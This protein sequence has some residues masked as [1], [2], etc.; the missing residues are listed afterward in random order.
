MNYSHKKE[1]SQAQ[2]L[3]LATLPHDDQ[4]KMEDLAANLPEVSWSELFLAIAILKR[5]GELV[6]Q[7][8]GYQYQVSL[9]KKRRRPF[10]ETLTTS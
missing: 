2:Q 8:C 3:I 4:V 5:R 10:I 9:A 6:L 7:R 1:Y